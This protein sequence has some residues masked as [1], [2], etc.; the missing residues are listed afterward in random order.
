MTVLPSEE[1]LFSMI[2]AI[3]AEA[4]CIDVSVIKPESRLFLDLDAESIDV[5]DI[6]FRIEEMYAI[7]IDQDHLIKSAGEG[8]G[9]KEIAE[10]FTAQFLVGYIRR[11]LESARTA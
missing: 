7:K 9:E 1:E 8:L 3:I 10:R 4:L 2:A 6:R 5:V 11:L